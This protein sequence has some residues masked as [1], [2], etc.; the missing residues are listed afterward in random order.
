MWRVL[1]TMKTL[2]KKE[3]TDVFNVSVYKSLHG[4]ET[5]LRPDP[6]AASWS[7]SRCTK[8]V[9]GGKK[10]LHLNQCLDDQPGQVGRYP[11]APGGPVQLVLV[12]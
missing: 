10:F 3:N 1:I 12:I 4:T 8:S 11:R 6:A 5:D 7:T 2:Y 9:L